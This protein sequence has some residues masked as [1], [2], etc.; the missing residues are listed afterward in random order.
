[1]LGSKKA[2]IEA[3]ISA[4]EKVLGSWERTQLVKCLLGKCEDMS[5]S[6]ST[7]VGKAGIVVLA[8]NPIAGREGW[9]G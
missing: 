6:T 3:A 4:S 5:S 8:Y 2:M 1:M 9:E 7:H